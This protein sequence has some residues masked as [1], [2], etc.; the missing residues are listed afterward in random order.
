MLFLSQTPYRGVY[1]F[2]IALDYFYMDWSYGHL[3]QYLIK[4][5]L[6]HSIWWLFVR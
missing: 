3:T 6:Q 5:N 4:L 1:R 2:A